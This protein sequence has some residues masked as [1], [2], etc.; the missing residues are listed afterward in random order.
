MLYR[1]IFVVLSEMNL[2]VH[3]TAIQAEKLHKPKQNFRQSSRHGDHRVVTC[4]EASITPTQAREVLFL[5]RDFIVRKT[6]GA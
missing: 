5:R 1:D 4:W 3:F 6:F 2:A